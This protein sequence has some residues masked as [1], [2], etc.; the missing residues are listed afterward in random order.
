MNRKNRP[1]GP[2]SVDRDRLCE[3]LSR[4]LDLAAINDHSCNGLQV[5]GAARVRR[6]GLAVD[7]CMETFRLAAARSCGMLVVHHG[8]IWGGLKNITGRVYTQVRYLIEH[9]LNLFAAHLPLDLHPTLGNNAQLAR[10]LG[11]KAL[12][13]FGVYKGVTIGCEGRAPSGAT[14]GALVERLRRRLDAACTVLPFGAEA[15]RRVA[16]VS[17]GGAGELAEAVD[18]GIDCYV[19]GEPS[20]E[21]YHVAREAG[22]NVVYAGHYHTEK[23]GVQEIGRL[24]ATTFGIETEF[25]DVP[26]AI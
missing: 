8:I 12:K 24:I 4:S 5:Q 11:L 20:H 16:V 15:V 22:I 19:T 13:P 14:R 6:V 25:L 23:A 7:A 3:F 18:K 17:G 26:T 21:N 9:D 2:K 10:L 1:S